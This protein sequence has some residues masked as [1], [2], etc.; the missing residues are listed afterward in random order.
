MNRNQLLAYVMYATKTYAEL[1]RQKSLSI[2]FA[3]KLFVVMV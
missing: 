2:L 3:V 1:V